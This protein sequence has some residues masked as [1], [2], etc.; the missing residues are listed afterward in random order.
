MVPVGFAIGV[1][2][3]VVF[4]VVDA[5]MAGWLDGWMLMPSAS[6]GCWVSNVCF[7]AAIEI[8]L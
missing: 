1:G 3:F 8:Y 7:P 2:D 5:M 4:V 6:R